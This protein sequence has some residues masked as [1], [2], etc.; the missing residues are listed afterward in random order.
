MNPKTLFYQIKN[1]CVHYKSPVHHISCSSGVN[2]RLHAGQPREGYLARLPC[3]TNS[4]LNKNVVP[5]SLL[6]LP[7]DE[8]AMKEVKMLEELIKEKVNGRHS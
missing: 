7:T 6:K 8:E 3:V 1:T 5:C 4:P 2:Y